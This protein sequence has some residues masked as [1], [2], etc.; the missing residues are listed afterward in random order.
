MMKFILH[1]AMI[2]CSISTHADWKYETTTNFKGEEQR[3][4]VAKTLNDGTEFW[5]DL[6]KKFAVIRTKKRIINSVNGVKID[7]R[8][9]DVN[10]EHG[11]DRFEYSIICEMTRNNNCYRQL[12][13]AKKIE[14]NVDYFR[15]GEMVSTFYPNAASD[16][17]KK[18]YARTCEAIN[19]YL[20]YNKSSTST[21][22]D[23]EDEDWLKQNCKCD[24]YQNCE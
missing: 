4:L 6:Q 18:Y 17:E 23:D 16:T 19:H 21:K 15:I 22:A 20:K 10:G 14:V 5:I 8:Y 1:T 13:N 3:Y 11:G 2:A 9:F 7:G 24:K 12:F